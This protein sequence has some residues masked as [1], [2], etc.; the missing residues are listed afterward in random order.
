MLKL[1]QLAVF[2]F[3]TG[4]TIQVSIDNNL[5]TSGL[6]ASLIGVT[7]AVGVTLIWNTFRAIGS[8]AQRIHS[9]PRQEARERVEPY[10]YQPEDQASSLAD[11]R[12]KLGRDGS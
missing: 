12:A 7:A 1:V 4:F 2:I 3:V 8:A 10:L 9:R 6:A 11:L 5:H